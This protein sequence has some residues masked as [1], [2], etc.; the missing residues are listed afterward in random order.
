MSV[1]HS[2]VYTLTVMADDGG[3]SVG[4]VFAF[5]DTTFILIFSILLSFVLY[6]PVL[7]RFSSE[8]IS[9]RG[10]PVFC[11]YLLG[12]FFVEKAHGS[13]FRSAKRSDDRA[14]FLSVLSALLTPLSH[15][16]CL[17]PTKANNIIKHT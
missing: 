12:I 8:G 6:S 16:A 14:L 1:F 9:N 4:V 17:H 15:F 2:H 5:V 10:M 11:Y 13:D 7:V 3:G